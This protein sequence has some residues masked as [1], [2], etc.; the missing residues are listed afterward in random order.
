MEVANSKVANSSPKE[1]NS[2]VDSGPTR[3]EVALLD[4]AWQSKKLIPTPKRSIKISSWKKKN[5]VESLKKINIYQYFSTNYVNTIVNQDDKEKEEK[6][7]E[8]SNEAIF[9]RLAKKAAEKAEMNKPNSIE[10]KSGKKKKTTT[11]TKK[12]K[13]TSKPTNKENNPKNVENTN[14]STDLIAD[15]DDSTNNTNSKKSNSRKYK[16]LVCFVIYL[17]IYLLLFY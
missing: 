3:V 13:A 4:M 16:G 7:D 12:T 9:A 10:E 17:S 15:E 2:S 8:T 6:V 1:P 14:N 11:T 5:K